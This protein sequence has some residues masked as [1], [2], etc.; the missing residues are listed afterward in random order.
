MTEHLTIARRSLADAFLRIDRGD[1]HLTCLEARIEV[2]RESQKDKVTVRVEANR[3][4]FGLRNEVEEPPR[5]LSV[6]IGEV[7][8]NLRAALD[9]LVYAL[10]WLDSR[11]HQ[12]KTQFPIESDC[13]IFNG[14]RRTFLKGVSDEHVAA[15]KR[16]Q[17]FNGCDWIGF[18]RDASNQDKHWALA[19]T[20]TSHSG[21]IEFDPPIPSPVPETYAEAFAKGEVNVK[22]NPTIDVTFANGPPVLEPLKILKAEVRAVLDSFKLEFEAS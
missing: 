6:L 8:Y 5:V 7:V 2:F 11:E 16:L 12:T 3:Q 1:E 13:E 18:L 17:P 19:V 14:R 10:A 4:G 22:H 20:S 15:I 9:Y 21:Y